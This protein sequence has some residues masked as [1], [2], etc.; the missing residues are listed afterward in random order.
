MS[1]VEN[2]VIE[3]ELWDLPIKFTC[4][5]CHCGYDTSAERTHKC[6]NFGRNS[7]AF[8]TQQDRTRNAKIILPSETASDFPAG[9]EASGAEDHSV[10]RWPFRHR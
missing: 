6:A 7:L 1:R 10:R 8:R 9:R 4:N 2:S 3:T 5:M